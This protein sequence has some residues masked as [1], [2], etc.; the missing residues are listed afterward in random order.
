M[1]SKLE[2]GNISKQQSLEREVDSHGRHL[3]SLG[4][5]CVA[6]QVREG[7]LFW[8]SAN[9][10]K[11]GSFLPVVVWFFLIVTVGLEE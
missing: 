2:L 10:C 3:T 6:V 9:Y 1:G 4:L 7:N 11:C 8:D 5:S